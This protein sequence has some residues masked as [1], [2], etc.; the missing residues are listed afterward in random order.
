MQTASSQSCLLCPRHKVP[1]S[2]ESL[3]LRP[4]FSPAGWFQRR[5]PKGAAARL[6]NHPVPA[7]SY[8]C[9]P[10]ILLLCCFCFSPRR[11]WNSVASRLPGWIRSVAHLAKL[12]VSQWAKH[13][14]KA[15]KQGRKGTRPSLL[16][17]LPCNW[18][19]GINN[20][21]AFV[22]TFLSL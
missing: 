1:P 12:Q 13:L 10:A 21:S 8:F 18:L 16:P 15:H 14:S 6:I 3:P 20:H 4:S 22:F 2:S 19:L 7:A 5:S 17:W 9:S 11:R